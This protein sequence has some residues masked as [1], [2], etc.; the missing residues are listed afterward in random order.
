M[1][2]GWMKEH[3]DLD[4]V[5]LCNGPYKKLHGAELPLP[6]MAVGGGM[7]GAGKSYSTNRQFIDRKFELL[8]VP[9]TS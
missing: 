9:G 5:H 3:G 7:S 1:P 6:Q 4:P 8:S 2:K